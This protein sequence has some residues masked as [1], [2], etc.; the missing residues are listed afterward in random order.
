MCSR[1]RGERQQRKMTV[2][3]RSLRWAWRKAPKRH[4]NLT[5]RKGGTAVEGQAMAT[6]GRAGGQA[7]SQ[8]RKHGGLRGVG[9]GYVPL[10]AGSWGFIERESGRGRY[11]K[12]EEIHAGPR[13]DGGAGIKS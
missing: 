3:R 6:R 7:K 10:A 4:A 1:V 11:G 9:V 12:P 5:G 2:T 13:G 8:R